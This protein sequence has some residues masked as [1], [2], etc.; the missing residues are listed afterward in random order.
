M[1]TNKLAIAVSLLMVLCACKEKVVAPDFLASN[2]DTTIKP[3][4]DFFLYANGG[5]IKNN[6]LG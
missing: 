6:K 5:W 3:S 1:K 4:E 2:I